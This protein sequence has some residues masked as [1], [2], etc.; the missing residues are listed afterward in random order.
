MLLDPTDVTCPQMRKSKL[1]SIDLGIKSSL[2][3]YL[4]NT[5]SMNPPPKKRNAYRGCHNGWSGR[6]GVVKGHVPSKR[7]QVLQQ[8]SDA[9][10]AKGTNVLLA[11]DPVGGKGKHKLEKALTRGL[12][13]ER[14]QRVLSLFTK[15][16]IPKKAR[17]GASV[18]VKSAAAL[19]LAAKRR[20]G[21]LV[22]TK[23]PSDQ[24]EYEETLVQTKKKY[25]SRKPA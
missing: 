11:Q 7:I 4:R 14:L 1:G 9:D 10:M 18:L 3:T 6:K 17:Y 24:H 25:A 12:F 21:D 2:F 5:S 13:N 19:H 15:P 16:L 23:A 20:R 22:S 8:T